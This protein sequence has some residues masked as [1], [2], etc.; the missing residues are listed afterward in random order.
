VD[1]GGLVTF[2]TRRVEIEIMAGDHQDLTGLYPEELCGALIRL[3]SGL[4]DA[5]HL[6]RDHGIPID[7]VAT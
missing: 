3:R 5:Q 7:P 6:A 2:A 1:E 4:V